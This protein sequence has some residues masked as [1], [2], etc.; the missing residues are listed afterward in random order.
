[1]EHKGLV[2]ALNF[3]GSRRLKLFVKNQHKQ[4]AKCIR[5]HIAMIIVMMCGMSQRVQL[6]LLFYFVWA[7]QS[8]QW[9]YNNHIV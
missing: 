9:F 1:M 4:I 2:N 3:L 7:D 6:F 5:E 8:V